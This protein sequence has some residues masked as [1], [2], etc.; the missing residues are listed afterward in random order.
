[1]NR[2]EVAVTLLGLVAT[3]LMPWPG[4][5]S[6]SRADPP[7]A[8]AE[9]KPAACVAVPT[10]AV[11]AGQRVVPGRTASERIPGRG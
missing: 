3:F 5:E 7:A 11:E 9:V 8:R 4:Q 1:M 6:S 2:S 10:A